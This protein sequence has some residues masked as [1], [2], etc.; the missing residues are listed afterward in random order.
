MTELNAARF[1][2][3]ILD[4]ANLEETIGKHDYWSNLIKNKW[5]IDY[6]DI[7]KFNDTAFELLVEYIAH[8][9]DKVKY[10]DLEQLSSNLYSYTFRVPNFEQKPYKCKVEFLEFWDYLNED[11]W[12]EN[13]IKDE[14]KSC[15]KVDAHNIILDTEKG[16]LVVTFNYIR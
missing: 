13:S 3:A 15:L 14:I 12:I 8:F 16:D 10:S 1:Y 6:I 4:K 9:I 7:D 11:C 2:K 5:D